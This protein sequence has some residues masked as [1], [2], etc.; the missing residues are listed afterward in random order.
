MAGMMSC[1][2]G[3][4]IGSAKSD[5]GVVVTDRCLLSSSPLASPSNSAPATPSRDQHHHHH[6][7]RLS[8]PRPQHPKRS[9]S[10]DFSSSSQVIVDL[11][12]PVAAAMQASRIND[13]EREVQFL[14]GKLTRKDKA[15]SELQRHV[16]QS[17]MKMNCSIGR[18][19]SGCKRLVGVNREQI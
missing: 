10:L 8:I 6:H 19:R 14:R 15:F 17:E 18:P 2:G 11:P 3:E 7:H 5:S 1:D 13:L 12:S 9:N 4:S 16:T